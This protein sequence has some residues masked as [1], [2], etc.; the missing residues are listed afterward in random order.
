MFVVGMIIR[1][2][3]IYCSVRFVVFLFKAMADHGY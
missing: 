2:A 1:A 3:V